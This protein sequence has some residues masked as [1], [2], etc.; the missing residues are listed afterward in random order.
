MRF[1]RFVMMATLLLVALGAVPARPPAVQAQGTLSLYLS[2]S[3]TSL[4]FGSVV[5]G[6]SS[7][8]LQVTVRNISGADLRLGRLTVSG[9]FKLRARD[10]HNKTLAPDQTCAFTVILAPENSG[11]LSG[12]VSVPHDRSST[13]D[14]V[15]LSG[16]GIP[17]TNILLYP[18]FDPPVPK[19]LPWRSS[20]VPFTA[21]YV[22]DCA[23]SISPFCSI[24]LQGSPW[25]YEQ[26]IS[27]AIWRNGKIGDRYLFR[28]SSRANQIPPGGKY[29]VE[30]ELRD[31][32]FEQVLDS[33]WVD[34]RDGTHDF[35]RVT[36]HIRAR[37]YYGWIVFRIVFQK[38]SGTA[39]FDN[40]ELIPLP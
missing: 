14:T 17:G 3:P 15:P 26:S 36:G 27:Q 20:P 29:R 11:Y 4:Y 12:Y 16:Y 2:F 40:A 31:P 34:F 19:P 28:L 8:P 21:H 7:S 35:E 6:A 23:I 10:C 25:D 1:A 9:P 18:N 24:R 39:W 5:V 37:M 32:A 33:A 22:W 30:V 13:P 38:S